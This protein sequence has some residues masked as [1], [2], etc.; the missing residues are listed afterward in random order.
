MAQHRYVEHPVT[1]K[2]DQLHTSGDDRRDGLPA[3]G[4]LGDQGGDEVIQ[5]ADHSQS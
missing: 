2:V 3:A 5:V 4:Q 1:E